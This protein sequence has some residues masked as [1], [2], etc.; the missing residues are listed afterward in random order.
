MP[1]G[2]LAAI[3][4]TTIAAGARAETVNP[5]EEAGDRV[6]HGLELYAAGDL[7]GARREFATAQALVPD[8]PN[9]YRLLA[10]VDVRL[11][12]CADAIREVDLFL[13]L[14]TPDDRRRAEATAMRDQCER[15]LAPKTGSITVTSRPSGAEVRLD[16]EGAAPAGATPLTLSSIAVGRHLVFLRKQGFE[17]LSR[18]V[19]VGPAER[20]RLDVT[21]TP[22]TPKVVV[23]T[24]DETVRRATEELEARQERAQVE[25]EQRARE[26]D[27]LKAVE[28]WRHTRRGLLISGGIFD[29]LGIAA[30]IVALTYAQKGAN[31]NSHIL[32]GGQT[33]MQLM[34]YDADVSTLNSIAIIVGTN[35]AVLG[36]IGLPLTIAGLAKL[37]MPQ[38]LAPSRDLTAAR[39]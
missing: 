33:T 35:A 17:D 3:I 27:R 24:N 1:R 34:Q 4:V 23:E 5:V 19:P 11:G 15:E 21:L 12:H 20:V 32:G 9:P 36:L 8:K 18:S 28:R 6:S 37:K 13:K 16:D 31:N 29:G 7:E 26:R 10:L 14:A 38:A 22:I 30:G 2:W 25:Q 39:Q